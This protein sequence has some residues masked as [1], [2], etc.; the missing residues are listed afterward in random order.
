MASHHC[1]IFKPSKIFTIE[2]KNGFKK[3]QVNL[4]VFTNVVRRSET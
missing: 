2:K 1:E 3:I 4:E